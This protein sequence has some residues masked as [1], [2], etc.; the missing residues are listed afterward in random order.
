MCAQGSV[1]CNVTLSSSET[2]YMKAEISNGWL[3]GVRY[4]ASPNHDERPENT[5]VS[6]LVI[7]SISLP[8]EEF[9]GPWIDRLFTNSIN[10]RAHAYFNEISDLRVSAHALIRRNGEIIQYVPFDKRA[11][12]AGESEFDGRSNCNDFSIGIELEGSDSQSFETI[13]Y[14]I[15]AEITA[16]LMAQYPDITP[17]RIAGHSDIAPG[18]KTD[19]GPN[20]D[21]NTYRSLLQE[22]KTIN[23]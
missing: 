18:R 22:N 6:L 20:F 12:H 9:G 8:P 4:L 3:G 1:V 21:W 23:A 10:T 15:L 16:L 11:W 2:C 17:Q 5:P 7:H 13:Q 14:K 19:P